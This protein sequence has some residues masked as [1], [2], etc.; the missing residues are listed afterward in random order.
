MNKMK[1]VVAGVFLGSIL[2]GCSDNQEE[3]PEATETIAEVDEQEEHAHGH[4]MERV[5]EEWANEDSVNHDIDYTY[6]LTL[7]ER[8]L[9]F[10]IETINLELSAENYGVKNVDGEGH[11]HI[12]LKKEGEKVG[13][14]IGVKENHFTK[15]LDLEEFPPGKYEVE[16]ELAENNHTPIPGTQRKEKTIII[17]E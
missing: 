3:E 1:L 15:E 10:D 17:E 12:W 4:D 11:A 2:V 6:E 8:V 7:D 5:P 14:R 16:V 13:T 9:T